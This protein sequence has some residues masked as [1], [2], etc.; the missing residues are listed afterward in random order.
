MNPDVDSTALQASSP[1]LNVASAHAR[2]QYSK[3]VLRALGGFLTR[4]LGSSGPAFDGNVGK[5]TRP[6]P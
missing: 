4:T 1:Q 5:V 2:K 6:S 3:P